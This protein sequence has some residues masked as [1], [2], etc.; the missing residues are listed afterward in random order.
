MECDGLQ[1]FMAALNLHA[2]G[3]QMP[4]THND[5]PV[6]NGERGRGSQDPL[7][8]KEKFECCIGLLKGH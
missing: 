4:S 5:Y 3:P 6:E 7:L 1:K 8:T 2:K